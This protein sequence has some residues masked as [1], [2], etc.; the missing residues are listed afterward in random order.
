MEAKEKLQL[1][2]ESRLFLLRQHG[3]SEHAVRCGFES[4]KMRS[5]GEHIF[6]TEQ[7]AVVYLIE[8]SGGY[9]LEE[10]AAWTELRPGSLFLRLPG[11]THRT[12]IDPGYASFYLAAPRAMYD[13]LCLTGTAYD[14]MAQVY[15]VGVLTPLVERWQALIEEL[16][17]ADS[18]AMDDYLKHIYGFLIH[19]LHI[20]RE[21]SDGVDRQFL[22]KACERLCLNLHEPL[23]MPDAAAEFAISYSAFRKRFSAGMG[24]APGEY[25]IRR[26]IDLAAQWLAEGLSSKRVAETLGYSDVFCF[27]KQFKRVT[28]TTPAR[29]QRSGFL[30]A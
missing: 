30:R 9:R 10:D 8:G 19:L 4:R 2:E 22:A 15:D 16:E 7:I 3:R 27:I 28:G 20:L 21:A 23:Y 1:L 5:E 29:Y 11:V 18:L 14:G 24:M 26:K 13:L 25:R 12:R 6:C 17:Q